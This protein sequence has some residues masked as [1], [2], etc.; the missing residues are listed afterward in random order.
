MTTFPILTNLRDREPRL[1]LKKLPKPRGTSPNNTR[2]KKAKP[3]GNF[4]RRQ[5]ARHFA[6]RGQV[7][8]LQAIY[9][10]IV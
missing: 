1:F 8:I 10:H 4:S 3:N 6:D 7:R 2:G 5:K 9:G